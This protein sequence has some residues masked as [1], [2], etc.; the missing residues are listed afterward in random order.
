MFPYTGNC[1]AGSLSNDSSNEYYQNNINGE[2]IFFTVSR[3]IRPLIKWCRSIEVSLV[4]ELLLHL[5]DIF[6]VTSTIPIDIWDTNIAIE[7]APA[8]FR[9]NS[10]NRGDAMVR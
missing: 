7:L 5:A 3:L 6:Q 1:D 9:S 10:I 2:D 8:D 4:T